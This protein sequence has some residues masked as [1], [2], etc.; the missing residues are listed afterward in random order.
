MP[1]LG[2][3]SSLSSR[4]FNP[5]GSGGLFPFTTATFTSGSTTGR[6]GPSLA[7]ARTG[8]TGPEASSWKNTTDYF[9]T[10]NGIQL[11]TVPAT[12]SYRIEAWG[13]QGG[14]SNSYRGGYGSRMRGDFSLIAGEIIRILVGHQGS[15]GGHTQDG[16]PVAAGGGGTYVVR[17]PYNSNASILVIAGGGG[18]SSNNTWSS[19]AGGDAPTY[20]D[21]GY[22]GANA[23]APGTAGQGGN[24]ST[25]CGGAGFFGNGATGSGSSASEMAASFTTGGRGGGNAR[26]W[27]GA[28]IYGGFGG[29]GGG[30]GLAAGGGG[31]YSGGAAGQWS[32]P[33][34]GGG[35]G[36][37]NNGTNQSN[38]A[39]NVGTATRSGSSSGQVIITRL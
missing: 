27:G 24:G 18:G 28:E 5:G 14:T 9:S 34:W 3:F 13:A 21:G 29:G 6:D 15:V 38:D 36:S 32:S 37:Y 1:I 23:F 8:L 39:G 16:N 11:W 25:S 7:A 22:G 26:S 12:G 17:T 35:G 4:G 20:N 30:G 19:A 10:T 2:S 33:Q 31:G